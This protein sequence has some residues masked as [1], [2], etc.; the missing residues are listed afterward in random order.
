M[1]NIYKV[2]YLGT[3]KKSFFSRDAALD[4]IF[5]NVGWGYGSNEDY[6]ILDGSDFPD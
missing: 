5:D 6:E 2:Y 1:Q 4:F 3:Y